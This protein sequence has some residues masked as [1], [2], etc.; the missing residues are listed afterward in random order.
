MKNKILSQAKFCILHFAFCISF[1]SCTDLD[2]PSDGRVE[3]EDIFAQ[4]NT[5]VSYYN[6]LLEEIPATGFTYRSGK[7]PTPLAVFCDEAEDVNNRVNSAPYNWY[8]GVTTAV[9]N[10]LYDEDSND[11]SDDSNNAWKYYFATIRRCN[12]FLQQIPDYT[13]TD[14]T[15]VEVAGMVAEVKV[16]RAFS[17]LQL[18]KRY[19]RLPLND[20]P[21]EVTHDYS[22]D[23]RASIEEVAD[24]IMADCDAALETPEDNTQDMSFLWTPRSSTQRTKIPRAFAWAVKSQT[25]LYAAS[26]LFYEAGS[27]Y[28]WGKAAEITK[29]ALDQCIAHGYE[30]YNRSMNE[31][32]NAKTLNTYGYYFIQRADPTR[33]LDKETIFESRLQTSIWTNAALPI[34]QGGLT[35]GPCPSQELVDAY[36]MQETGLPIDDPASGYDET[37]LYDGRDPRFYASIYYNGALFKWKKGESQYFTPQLLFARHSGMTASDINGGA[38]GGIDSDT[39][40]IETAEANAYIETGMLQDKIKYDEAYLVFDYISNKDANASFYVAAG[41]KGV[42]I[43]AETVTISLPK[44]NT[45]ASIRY[46]LSEFIEKSGFGKLTIGTTAPNEHRLG[47]KLS[48]AD[49]TIRICNWKIDMATPPQPVMSVEA[50]VGGSCGFSENTAE[51][52]RT[53]TGYYMRKFNSAASET[54]NNDDGYFKI[55]RLGELYLNFAEAAYNATSP[56][57]KY[58]SLSARDAVNAVRDRAGMPPLP[59]M[60]NADFEKRY[61]NERRVELAFEEHRFFDVRRWKILNETDKGVHGM[62]ITLKNPPTDSTLVYERVPMVTRQTY[63]DK[64]LLYPIP[65]TEVNKMLQYTGT[66]WQNPGW[67]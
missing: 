67:E 25:A 7:N 60:S 34:V 66:S 13:A 44:A 52:R 1:T 14:I 11:D 26:P 22:Q 48:E 57:T 55:F 58:G 50:H 43:S 45:G 16:I 6:S 12:T 27:K 20:K 21:Y 23:K 65:Q 30:L 37:N 2:M 28:G 39:I 35:A 56:D 38:G 24:S 42:P 29:A 5:I 10:P 53:R 36:E 8:T 19:G 4:R 31:D 9:N 15:A 33:S 54:G 32:M 51:T 3:L 46:N 61:R 18:M 17:Y 64:Y 47:L 49:L 41:A 62:K 63:T 40:T 59:S